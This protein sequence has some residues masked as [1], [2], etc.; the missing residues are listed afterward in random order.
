[1]SEQNPD[2]N[3]NK[4]RSSFGKEAFIFISSLG[5]Y[6]LCSNLIMDPIVTDEGRGEVVEDCPASMEPLFSVTNEADARASLR[7]VV[8]DY[9][10]RDFEGDRTTF[11]NEDEADQNGELFCYDKLGDGTRATVLTPPAVEAVMLSGDIEFLTPGVVDWITSPENEF[12]SL[13][14]DSFIL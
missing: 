4:K 10:I 13:F 9:S 6:T 5:I 2:S 14:L 1:M 7:A 12:H 8:E 3:Y 11:W